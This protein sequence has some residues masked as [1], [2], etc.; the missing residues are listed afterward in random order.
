M[1]PKSTIHDVVHDNKNSLY[2]MKTDI[3]AINYFIVAPDWSDQ[4]I[5]VEF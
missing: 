2:K 4:I 3:R 1:Y 5:G